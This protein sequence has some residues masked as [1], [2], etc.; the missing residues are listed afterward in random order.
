VLAPAA[1]LLARR[2][3]LAAS[4]RALLRAARASLERGRAGVAELAGR[5]ESLSP[6]GVLTRGYAIVRRV[7]DGAIVR[8][9]GD[10]EPGERVS[11]RVAE[12]EIEA[13]VA[14]VRALRRA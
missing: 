12:A 13:A 8:A 5:L 9:A 14:A 3:R 7:R 4:S 2:Q 11:L 1:Q 6:L 10:V